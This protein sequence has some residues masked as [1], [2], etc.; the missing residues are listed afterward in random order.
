[1][2][3]IPTT[4]LEAS[5]LEG[6]GKIAY[7]LWV[8]GEGSLYA[9]MEDNTVSSPSPS[10]FPNLLFQVSRYATVRNGPR[11]INQFEGHGLS[12]IAS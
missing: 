1:M 11:S 9:Q 12:T 5:K 10:T 8:D 7:K 4:T 2:K 3:L 6:S